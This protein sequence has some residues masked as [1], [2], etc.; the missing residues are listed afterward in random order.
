MNTASVN[1]NLLAPGFIRRGNVLE[2][3]SKLPRDLLRVASAGLPADGN[4]HLVADARSMTSRTAPMA[5]F[6]NGFKTDPDGNFHLEIPHLG[7]QDVGLGG[8]TCNMYDFRV[9][10]LTVAGSV[11]HSVLIG[12]DS[13]VCTSALYNFQKPDPSAAHPIDPAQPVLKIDSGVSSQMVELLTTGNNA[14]KPEQI[15][16]DVRKLREPNAKETLKQKGFKE[17]DAAS[18]TLRKGYKGQMVHFNSDGR[19]CLQTCVGKAW[20]IIHLFEDGE[21]QMRETK[22][23]SI[24]RHISRTRPAKP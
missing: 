11:T 18:Y 8:F 23:W 22:N 5:L 3:D 6:A 12:K 2:L 1:V 21:V 20:D 14:F 4:E 7:K 17:E 16:T 15:I 24:L 13:K 9:N 19:I 10:I